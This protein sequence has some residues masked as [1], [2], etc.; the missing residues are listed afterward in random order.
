M[1]PKGA[2]IFTYNTKPSINLLQQKRDTHPSVIA[3]IYLE[4]KR[5][6]DGYLITMFKQIMIVKLHIE[7]G[8]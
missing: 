2:N 4:R 6:V 8:M 5:I 1:D 3:S 7:Q